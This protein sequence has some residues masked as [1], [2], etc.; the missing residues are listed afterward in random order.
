MEEERQRI[1]LH[2][3]GKVYG[4]KDELFLSGKAF[5]EFVPDKD[6]CLL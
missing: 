6:E 2:I 3:P 1:L 5:V 4:T